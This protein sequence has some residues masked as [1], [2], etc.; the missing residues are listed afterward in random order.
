MSERTALI[1]RGGWEGHAPVEATELF[2][3]F[4]REQGFEVRIEESPEVYA[5]ADALAA[6]DL[7]VQSMT[8]SEI[9]HDQ[10]KGLRAAVGAGTGM[11]G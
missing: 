7:I 11:A 10:L 3:P 5:D 6:T 2:L 4:L 9:S 8:M 1:V